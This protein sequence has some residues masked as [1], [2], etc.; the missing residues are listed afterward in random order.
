M[1]LLRT[2]VASHRITFLAGKEDLIKQ[3]KSNTVQYRAEENNDIHI[4]FKR[5]PQVKDIQ[6]AKQ[7]HHH[8]SRLL[9]SCCI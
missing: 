5:D 3:D 4:K 8:H 2:R 6:T 7:Q 9:I 1:N